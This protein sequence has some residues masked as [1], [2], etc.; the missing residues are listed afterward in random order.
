MDCIVWKG[1][2]GGKR[3]IESSVEGVAW[4]GGEVDMHIDYVGDKTKW[5]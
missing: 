1:V 3:S 5:Q 2:G 4:G